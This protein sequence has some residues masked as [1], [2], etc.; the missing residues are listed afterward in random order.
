MLHVIL[1]GELS[2]ICN[3]SF[4]IPRFQYIYISRKINYQI[5]LNQL[6]LEQTLFEGVDSPVHIYQDKQ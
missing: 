3:T 1:V 5:L 6:T 4:I 2:D